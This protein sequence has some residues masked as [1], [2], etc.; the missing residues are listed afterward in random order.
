MNRYHSC[1]LVGLLSC[2]LCLGTG[3]GSADAAQFLNAHNDDLQIYISVE[4]WYG[5]L[6][7][8][9]IP[10]EIV[11]IPRVQGFLIHES[12]L[13]FQGALGDFEIVSWTKREEEDRVVFSYRLQTFLSPK[14]FPTL[15]LGSLKLYY[16]AKKYWSEKDQK[17]VFQSIPLSDVQISQI[18]LD[19]QNRVSPH[20][21][22]DFLDHSTDRP[23][24]FIV[25]GLLSLSIPLR[26]QIK[27]LWERALG[28]KIKER[29]FL[30]KIIREDL[31]LYDPVAL[32][33]RLNA[34]QKDDLCMKV[35]YGGY[36]PGGE[37]MKG[38]ATRILHELGGRKE[39]G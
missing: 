12:R 29:S 13:P 19:P 18:S 28:K 35:L 9:V 30:K 2:L 16:T 27:R 22:F 14:K 32:C 26:P 3:S 38:V 11:I 24:L 17:Y 4:K 8:D 15:S 5:N 1:L 23:Y 10:L 37:E 25:L 21:T 31:S 33:R 6:I 39:G 7:G 34:I 20:R 36:H